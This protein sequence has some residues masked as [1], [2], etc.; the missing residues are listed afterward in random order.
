MV[1][2]HRPDKYPFYGI[3]LQEYD[4]EKQA[5]LGTPELIFKGT[6]LGCTEGPH[7]YQREGYYYLLLAEGG[8]DWEHCVTLARSS[9]INGPYGL[10]PQNPIL[11][12]QGDESLTLQKAGHGDLVETQDG[13]WYLFHLCSRP[14][15][16]NRRC[17][18]GRETAVQR[19]EWRDND[20][21]YLS[22]GGNRPSET[23]D[24]PNLPE[25]TWKSPP[26]RDEFD[27]EQLPLHYQMPR[28]VFDDAV[29]S[30]SERPGFLRLKGRESLS[31]R[32][33]STVVARRIETTRCQGNHTIRI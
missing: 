25:S 18:L 5:L 24:A 1:H 12:S 11:T 17:I 21:L 10:H 19:V 15:G 7:L 27:D 16:E 28:T 32:F 22:R 6:D 3:T 29:G 8:T 14:V 33:I 26:Q 23:Y 20:W 30:L 13:Q 4:L 9:A 2:D 31:S